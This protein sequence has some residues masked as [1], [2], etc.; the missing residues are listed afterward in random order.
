MWQENKALHLKGCD[1][2]RYGDERYS[3]SYEMKDISSK[4]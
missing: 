4:I 1:N 2:I 3:Y